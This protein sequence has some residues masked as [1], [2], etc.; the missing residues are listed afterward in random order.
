MDNEKLAKLK[1]LLNLVDAGLTKTDFINS[2]K[3]VIKLTTEIEKRLVQ[4]IDGKIKETDNETQRMVNAME[5]MRGQFLQT[6]KETKSANE[7]TFAQ[8]KLRAMESMQAMFSKMDIQGK[9]DA[10]QKEHEAMMKKCE[11]KM[12]D[13]E[14]MMTEMLAKVPQETAEQARDKLETLKDDER[15]DKSAVKGIAEIEKDVKEIKLRPAGRI[16]GG[17]RGVMLYV[18]G[19]KRGQANMLNIVPGTGVSFTYAYANGRNDI[20]INA[21]A[22]SSILTATGAVDGVNTVYTF[23]SSPT[24]VIV[25]GVSY[26]DGHGATIVSTTA[27][28]DFAPVATS[29][30]YGIA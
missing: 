12:P 3:E 9:M 28:L 25:N 19:T 6:I 27:T 23:A 8:I 29:D 26:R 17:A 15:L 1:E 20:T 4:K 18:D 11:A 14:K 13:T 2:F 24:V 10:M 5:E 16:A 7:S 30:V 22:S 21:S